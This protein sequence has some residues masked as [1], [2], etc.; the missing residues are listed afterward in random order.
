MI[1]KMGLIC[2]ALDQRL[3]VGCSSILDLRGDYRVSKSFPPEDWDA[4]LVKISKLSSQLWIP[5]QN[6]T[7][8]LT[9]LGD[10]GQT[11]VYLNDSFQEDNALWMV[12]TTV[13]F[14]LG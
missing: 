7:S 4:N 5:S 9:G 11:N 1:T 12:K 14:G 10:T 3:P 13:G 2:A 6:F 8:G